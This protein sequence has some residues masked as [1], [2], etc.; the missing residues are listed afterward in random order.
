MSKEAESFI[1]DLAETDISGAD[2][3]AVYYMAHAWLHRARTINDAINTDIEAG[4][5]DFINRPLSM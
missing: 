4:T 5:D 2:A 1:K 3:I